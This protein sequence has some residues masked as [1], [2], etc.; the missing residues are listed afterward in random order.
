MEGPTQA[1]NLRDSLVEAKSDIVVKIGLRKGS[2]SF[3]EARLQD[4]LKRVEH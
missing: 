3:A 1:Q 4:S 2:R